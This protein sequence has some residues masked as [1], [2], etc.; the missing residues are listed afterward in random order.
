MTQDYYDMRE[1]LLALL[2]VG[3]AIYRIFSSPYSNHY[4]ARGQYNYSLLQSD[5]YCT[6]REYT[7]AKILKNGK[8]KIRTS[9]GNESTES[10]NFIYPYEGRLFIWTEDSLSAFTHEERAA[11]VAEILD[12]KKYI[13]P[14]LK[15]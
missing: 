13:L 7:V 8:I 6:I 1:G 2:C 3:D 9:G 12:A 11:K 15:A 14:H 5:T 10:T 4:V